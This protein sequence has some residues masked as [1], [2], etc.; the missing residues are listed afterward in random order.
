MKTASIFKTSHGNKTIWNFG[1]YNSN[2]S[3]N[4]NSA[5][6]KSKN[7]AITG[8]RFSGEY[9]HYIGPDNRPRSL[10]YF[11]ITFDEISKLI[12]I[13]LKSENIF[14]Y[15][16]CRC[17]KVKPS[18]T[19]T[20]EKE[21]ARKTL[22]NSIHSLEKSMK[23]ASNSMLRRLWKKYFGQSEKLHEIIIECYDKTLEDGK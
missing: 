13:M 19:I 12:E 3:P 6:Y 11:P 14:N 17:K 1:D 22:N 5:G 9:T 18:K 16:S 2:P 7:A 20:A 15:F 4:Q 21:K 23:N 8:C 10:L